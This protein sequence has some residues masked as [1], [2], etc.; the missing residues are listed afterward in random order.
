MNAD[1]SNQ[2]R[3]TTTGHNGSP[4]FNGDGSKIAF[5]SGNSLS[6]MGVDNIDGGN[7][8]NVIYVMNADGSNRTQLT[9]TGFDLDPSFSGDGS[10]IAFN[11][12]R[13][14]Q[15]EIYV[16]NAD[17][18]NQTRLTTTGDN[19]HPSF[20]QDGSKIAFNVF[21]DGI[22]EIYVM[23]AD[24]SGRTPLGLGGSPSFSGCPNPVIFVHETRKRK[25]NRLTQK[26][27]LRRRK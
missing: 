27:R 6:L 7:P 10:K 18:S 15:N 24:G 2:T 20:S 4:S 21:H 9:T 23:N 17:G 11:S 26:H 1:G 19:Y 22:S 14:F 3:L 12:T 8:N 25:T 16:M 5:A 13:D